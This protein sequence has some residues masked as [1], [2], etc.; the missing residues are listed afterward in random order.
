MRKAIIAILA[1][2]IVVVGALALAVINVNTLLEENREELARLASDATGREITFEKAEVA[3][4]GRLSIQIDGLRVAEDPRFGK[5]DF[6]ALDTA[7]VGV[8][9][10]PAL[11]NRLALTG[12]RLDG[13]TI[14]VIQSAHGFNFS[15][16]GAAEEGAVAPD[17][18]AP[19]EEGSSS[20]ALAI[21][22]FRILDATILFEDRTS[23][24][25]L[26]I[27]VENFE[28]SG[29][30]LFGS[31]PIEIAFSGLAR[32]TNGDPKL[33][34]PFLGDILVRDLEAG[35]LDLRLESPKFHPLLLGIDLEEGDTVERLDSVILTV[36]VPPGQGQAEYPI[37]LKS[38][39]GR[40]AGFDYEELDTTLHYLGSGLDIKNLDIGLA[41][42]KVELAGDMTFGPPGRAPFKLDTKLIA[43]DTG[44]LAAI[45]LGVPRGYV[46]GTI[47]GDVDLAGD[48][49]D[50]E[51]LK[52]T[53]AGQVK[54]EV[55]EGALEK[56]NVVDQVVNR[57]LADP[58][59]GQL[60]A[61]SIRDVAPELLEGDRTTFDSINLAFDVAN[62]ALTADEIQLATSKFMLTAAGALGLDGAVSGDGKIEFSEEISAR[63][64][65]KADKLAPLLGDGK[66]VE[67]PLLIGG[68]TDSMQLLPDLVALTE[69][70][71]ANATAE[72]RLEAAEKLTDAIF[73]KKKETVEGEEPTQADK[74]RDAATDLINQGLGK[75][76]GK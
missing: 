35:T 33:G 39:A 36:G 49:L 20:M 15:S 74:D 56:V 34:S 9:I 13:P 18:R 25:P 64:I 21:A 27:T 46:T 68:T 76:F 63:I 57:L 72:V 22:G 58:G 23:N 11:Q 2:I 14:R 31:D 26:A 60:A 5:D 37:T 70:A 69:T 42:G 53:L 54:L 44:E 29:S 48:S 43:L 1:L 40:L 66:V 30:E 71:R 41:G 3:F 24:P 4:P 32:P 52:K 61:N 47:G 51:T 62:G 38:S 8:E 6:L 59:L 17:A 16:L 50:W 10:M 73:G 19:A 45:L 75:L 12:L 28:S 67:L 55:G 7:Y 65:E